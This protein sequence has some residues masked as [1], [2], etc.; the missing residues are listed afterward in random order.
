MYCTNSR[1][2]TPL[3]IL[4]SDTVEVCGGSRKLM[5]ILNQLGVVASRDRY[6]TSVVEKMREKS[7]WDYMSNV[8]FTLASVDN[9]DMLKSQAAV[10]CGDQYRSYHGTTIQIAQPL[11]DLTLA[12]PQTLG[13]QELTTAPLNQHSVTVSV[14]GNKQAIVVCENAQ[15]KSVSAVRQQQQTAV[16]HTGSDTCMLPSIKRKPLS[17]ANSPHKLG[18]HGPKR[19][20]TVAVRNLSDILSTSKH[21]SCNARTNT[22]YTSNLWGYMHT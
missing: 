9:F 13:P 17:P 10:Y 19:R 20:R 18:K 2:P 14:L 11:P 12:A 22:V 21:T 3:H 4:L 6:V 7:I 16:V 8:I 15:E 1:T 5:R